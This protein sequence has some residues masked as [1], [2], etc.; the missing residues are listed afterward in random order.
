MT[1]LK[2][3]NL[4]LRSELASRSH[5]SLSALNLLEGTAFL[6]YPFNDKK[7]LSID[8]GSRDGVVS[9][10]SAV[11]KDQVLV[12][13]ITDV[14]RSYSLLR[15]VFDPTWEFPVYIGSSESRGLFQAGVEPRVILISKN[16]SLNVGDIITTADP[17]LFPKSLVVGTV[18][19]I[20]GGGS[21]PFWEVSVN[22][23]Y[24]ITEIRRLFLISYVE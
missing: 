8:I 11:L 6:S 4:S 23:P 16:E 9:G 20:D 17:R 2:L 18:G 15:T 1:R 12:G 5:S 22:I 19:Q 13:Q 21:S 24:S 14:F 10:S 3:E 7:T